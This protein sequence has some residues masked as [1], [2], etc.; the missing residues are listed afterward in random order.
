MKA[1]VPDARRRDVRAND[2][3]EATILIR[4]RLLGRY[5]LIV[6]FSR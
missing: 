4:F 5:V 6:Q 3:M 2:F 1:L